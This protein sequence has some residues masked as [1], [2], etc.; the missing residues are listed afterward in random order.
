MLCSWQPC[1]CA[2]DD[3]R[4]VSIEVRKTGEGKEPRP[5]N[6][7]GETKK[8]DW[9]KLAGNRGTRT[10]GTRQGQGKGPRKM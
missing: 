1:L 3:E 5:R 4:C 8:G 9:G 7:A 6:A 2:C 10:S